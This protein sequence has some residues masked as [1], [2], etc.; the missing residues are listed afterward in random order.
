MPAL[1]AIGEKIKSAPENH[2]QRGCRAEDDGKNWNDC[3]I[4]NDCTQET[5]QRRGEE[6][7]KQGSPELFRV[8]CD[9]WLEES[10]P[11]GEEEPCDGQREERRRHT[12]KKG[13]I[14]FAVGGKANEGEDGEGEGVA[15]NKNIFLQENF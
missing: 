1:F 9:F 7:R 11:R 15:E 10:K 3:C 12:W 4:E 6:H 14:R 2:P 13:Q 8:G 5:R